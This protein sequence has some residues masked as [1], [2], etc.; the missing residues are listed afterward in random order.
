[1]VDKR[2]GKREGAGRKPAPEGTAKVAYATKLAPL[3]VEYLRQRE[4][5]A[6]AIET[7]IEKSKGY[8]EWRESS[9]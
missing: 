7:A 2:G 5:A 9:R 6:Q 4:N 3:I 8:R 1:M